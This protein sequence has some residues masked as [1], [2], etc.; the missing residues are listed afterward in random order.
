[1]A[2]LMKEGTHKALLSAEKKLS[3]MEDDEWVNLEVRTKAAIILC[4]SD[5]FLYNVIKK[6]TIA[7][8]WCKLKSLNMT[9]SLSKQTLLEESVI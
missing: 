5:E 9:K 8:L 3:R 2:L 7:V 6:E 1:M 4:L